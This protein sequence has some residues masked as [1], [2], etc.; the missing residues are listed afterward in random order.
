MMACE[1]GLGGNLMSGRLFI[2]RLAERVV[3]KEPGV[4]QLT[5]CACMTHTRPVRLKAGTSWG[6]EAAAWA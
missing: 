3:W 2:A 6:V 4:A 5:M 1:G